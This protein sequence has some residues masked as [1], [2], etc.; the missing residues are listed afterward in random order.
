MSVMSCVLLQ[1]MTAVMTRS[2]TALSLIKTRQGHADRHGV[3]DRCLYVMSVTTHT[4]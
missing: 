1:N 3:S 2:A 4:I